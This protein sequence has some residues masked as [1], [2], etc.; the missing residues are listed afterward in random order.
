[1]SFVIT[2]ELTRIGEYAIPVARGRRLLSQQ[3]RVRRSSK[4]LG[5]TL[6][7]CQDYSRIINIQ[8]FNDV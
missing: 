4:L 8:D 2:L 7:K 1:M 6:W 5:R 3:E